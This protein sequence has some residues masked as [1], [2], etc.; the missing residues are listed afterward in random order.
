MAT[1]RKPRYVQPDGF[2]RPLVSFFETRGLPLLLA[3]AIALSPLAAAGQER[4][5]LLQLD[6]GQSLGVR[7]LSHPP[8]AH[9][10]D[11]PEPLEPHSALATAKLVTRFLAEGRVEEASLLS[12]S[13]KARYE[14]MRESFQG[15]TEDDFRRTYGS[16]FAPENQILGEVAIGDHR[17]LM[18]HLKE[19]DH[20]AAFYLVNIEGRL[21]LDDI[22]N[23]TRN[24]LRR[25]LEAYRSGKFSEKQ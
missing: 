5:L 4:F 16:Y 6:S 2:W 11:T 19:A 24:N 7:L 25:V 1:Q 18:W 23:P 12:N 9:L 8:D 21:L 13:P 22:P 17:L 10:V 15:W 20:V 14:R 3:A